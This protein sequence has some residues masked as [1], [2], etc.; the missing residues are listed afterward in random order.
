[1]ADWLAGAIGFLSNQ[2]VLPAVAQSEPIAALPHL[3]GERR[4]VSVLDDFET[5]FQPGHHEGLHRPGRVRSRTAGVGRGGSPAL[6][7]ADQPRIAADELEGIR[8][9]LPGDASS[10]PS[11]PR[12]Q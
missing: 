5:L 6:A 11:C 12:H 8:E 4:C 3:M 10:D 9:Q 1:V 7:G 2:Q